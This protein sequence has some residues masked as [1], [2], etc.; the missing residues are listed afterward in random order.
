MNLLPISII[1]ELD[2]NHFNH[3][4]RKVWA[5]ELINKN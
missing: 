4:Y 5:I 1:K 2:Y 3:T